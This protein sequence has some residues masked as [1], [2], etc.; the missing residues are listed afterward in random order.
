MPSSGDKRKE[1]QRARRERQRLAKASTNA[2]FS[3]D[4]TALADVIID[5]LQLLEQTDPSFHAKLA[6]AG[7]APAAAHPRKRNPVQYS[8][9]VTKG[10]RTISGRVAAASRRR[11]ASGS[12]ADTYKR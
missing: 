3:T 7:C 6:S 1:Q 2:E 12:P 5:N 10:H 4:R 11:A 8:S 9:N